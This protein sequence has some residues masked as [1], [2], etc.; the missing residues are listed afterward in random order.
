MLRQTSIHM[1]GIGKQN[2][3]EL[4]EHG[5]HSWDDTDR[6]EKRGGAF[7]V[8][9]GCLLLIPT[10]VSADEAIACNTRVETAPAD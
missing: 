1:P 8:Q 5:I 3:R 10:M 2:E 6:F 9:A 7:G 4:W